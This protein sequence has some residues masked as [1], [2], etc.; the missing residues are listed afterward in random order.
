MSSR[1]EEFPRRIAEEISKANFEYKGSSKYSG[2][3]LEIDR[4]NGSMDIQFYEKL[5]QGRYIVTLE[6][7]DKSLLN[8][9]E[10]GQI[11]MFEFKVYEA[12]LSK[13]LVSLLREKYQVFMNTINKFELVSVERIG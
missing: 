11:Y 9:M 10:L 12:K 5:P 3:P 8:G 6:T 2:Y 1:E 13:E 7:P 4:K